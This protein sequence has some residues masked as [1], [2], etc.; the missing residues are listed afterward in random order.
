MDCKD[1]VQEYKPYQ[2]S[3]EDQ[4]NHVKDYLTVEKDKKERY[5]WM[6]DEY[7]EKMVRESEERQEASNERLRQRLG[8][9]YPWLRKVGT[10][11]TGPR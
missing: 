3:G 8:K 4:D 1:K 10:E 6:T 5:Y 2:W 7:R 11:S 9:K